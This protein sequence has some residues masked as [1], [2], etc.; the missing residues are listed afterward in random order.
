LLLMWRNAEHTNGPETQPPSVDAAHFSGWYLNLK[1]ESIAACGQCTSPVWVIDSTSV[2]PTGPRA[3]FVGAYESLRPANVP[4]RQLRRSRRSRQS[5]RHW[6][7]PSRSR[8]LEN[9]AVLCAAHHSVNA[10]MR[11]DG[12]DLGELKR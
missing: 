3:D 6:A 12:D 11:K 4:T 8:H 1:M 10:Q 5:P 2:L 7:V 9:I